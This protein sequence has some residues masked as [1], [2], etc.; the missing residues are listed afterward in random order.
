MG[1]LSLG[2]CADAIDTL[3]AATVAVARLAPEIEAGM[4]MG[5]NPGVPEPATRSS[6]GDPPGD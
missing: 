5:V 6:P 2:C 4:G 3:D 1:G